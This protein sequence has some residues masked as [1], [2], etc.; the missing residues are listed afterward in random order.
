KSTT[1]GGVKEIRPLFTAQEIIDFQE[2]IR[3]I[4]VA[5]N[6]I[7]YAVGLVS[8]TRP[9][10]QNAANIVKEYIEWGAG[11]RASQNLILAAKVNAAVKGK[12]SPD[13]EDVQSVAIG[14]LRHRIVKNYK[15]EAEGITEDYIIK[16]LF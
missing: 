7:E 10:E 5:D 6:V 16:E 8:K 12:F 3:R 15:A 13:I 2:L 9:Q 1:S 14:I 11:P 4:P